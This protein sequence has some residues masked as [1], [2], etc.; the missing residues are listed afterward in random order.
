MLP[1]LILFVVVSTTLNAAQIIGKTGDRTVVAAEKTNFIDSGPERAA[2]GAKSSRAQ[3]PEGNLPSI[4]KHS[5]GV[6]DDPNASRSEMEK[7][8][9]DEGDSPK[10]KSTAAPQ[11]SN[12]QDGKVEPNVSTSPRHGNNTKEEKLK[13]PVNR[14]TS[15]ETYIFPVPDKLDSGA[16]LRGFY[17]FVGLSTMALLY[18]IFRTYRYGF[19]F[20]LRSPEA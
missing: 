10:R 1:A 2:F 17:V 18:V 15:N 3:K 4:P 13:E 7:S 9:G 8:D 19:P 16:L 11:G 14:I 5:E 6:E 20:P 12:G